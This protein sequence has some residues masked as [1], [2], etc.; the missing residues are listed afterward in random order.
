MAQ[1]LTK[2]INSPL[3][4]PSNDDEIFYYIEWPA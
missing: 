3:D 4:C 1:N 2:E